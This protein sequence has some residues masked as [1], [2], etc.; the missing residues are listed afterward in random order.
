MAVC[1]RGCGNTRPVVLSGSIEYCGGHKTCGSGLAREDG[2]SVDSNV[3]WSTAIASK[4]APTGSP[5]KQIDHRYPPGPVNN[6][7]WRF[8]MPAGIMK[9][10][11]CTHSNVLEMVLQSI[12]WMLKAA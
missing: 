11:C 8:F 4:L 7:A 5:V 6:G 1:M 10:P 2:V 9:K 3:A 12:G